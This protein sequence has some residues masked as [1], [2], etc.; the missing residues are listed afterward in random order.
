[1]EERLLMVPGPT[2]LSK[3]VRDALAQA[4]VGHTD[5]DF[6]KNFSETLRASPGGPS[7]T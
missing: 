1:M 6:V 2:N 7:G 4:Q 5:P 3:R